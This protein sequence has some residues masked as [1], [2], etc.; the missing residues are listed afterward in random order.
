MDNTDQHA[1]GAEIHMPVYNTQ[2][3]PQPTEPDF[4]QGRIFTTCGFPTDGQT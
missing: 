1:T 4:T 2:E 3:D